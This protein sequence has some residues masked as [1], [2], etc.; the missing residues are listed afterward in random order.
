MERQ[1]ELI[2]FLTDTRIYLSEI[3]DKNSA[4]VHENYSSD[5]PP[6]EAGTGLGIAREWDPFEVWRR[7][8]KSV[9]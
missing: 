1:S 4:A 2:R 8:I 3:K 7:H 5:S 9:A 6:G